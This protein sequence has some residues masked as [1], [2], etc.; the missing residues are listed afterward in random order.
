MKRVTLTP[1]QISAIHIR[2]TAT[3]TYVEIGRWDTTGRAI[4]VSQFERQRL[5]ETVKIMPGGSVAVLS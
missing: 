4:E 3:C 5:I 2:L 1:A